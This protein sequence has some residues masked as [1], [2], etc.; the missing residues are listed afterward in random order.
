ALLQPPGFDGAADDAA[1]SGASGAARGH[2]IRHGF[3]TAGALYDDTGK[4][5]NGRTAEDHKKSPA[6]GD[7]L[8]AQY[9]SFQPVPGVSVNA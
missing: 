4:L 8:A 5:H 1:T 2:A 7:A 9:R 6:A 3:D